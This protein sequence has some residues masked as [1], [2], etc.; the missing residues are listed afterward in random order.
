VEVDVDVGLF[1]GNAAGVQG[2][3][4]GGLY[5]IVGGLYFLFPDDDVRI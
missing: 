2:A 3:L 5:F 1:G 4:C